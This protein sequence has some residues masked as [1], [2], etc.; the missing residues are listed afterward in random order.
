[1][2]AGEAHKAVLREPAG[3]LLDIGSGAGVHAEGFRAAGFRVTTLD[4]KPPA[5]LIGRYTHIPLDPFDYIW[6][7]HVLEHQPDPHGFLTKCFVDLN[8]N[9]MLAITVPPLKHEIVGGHVSLWNAGLLLY[10]LVLAGF[11]CSE[12][13]VKTYGYNISVLVRKKPAVLP[14][15]KWDGGDIERLR[16]Y[17]PL[18][19]HE[20]FDGRIESVN[21]PAK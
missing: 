16:D 13:R 14:E 21:W 19:V 2:W 1:M 3:T 9:G 12:A 20:G 18:P 15:L 10:R 5:D 6:A 7:S 4:I 8:P 17:F 11:D